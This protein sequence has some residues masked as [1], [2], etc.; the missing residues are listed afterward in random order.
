MKIYIE[1]EKEF[2]DYSGWNF[3]DIYKYLSENNLWYHG[4]E[5]DKR[6]FE[7]GARVYFEGVGWTEVVES[8]RHEDC[9]FWPRRTTLDACVNM[10]ECVGTKRKDAKSVAFKKLEMPESPELQS[11]A[12]GIADKVKKA[13]NTIPEQG[14]KHDAGKIRPSLIPVECIEEIARVLTYGAEK[15][16]PDN[17]K[18]V[19]PERY[20]DALWRHYIAWQKGEKVDAESGLSHAAHFATNAIF[21]LWFEIQKEKKGTTNEKY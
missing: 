12:R 13:G 14:I 21:L 4:K 16:A 1:H 10:P 5:T 15:Y 2:Y 7:I 9:V 3:D 20:H 19:S 18:Q 6:G 8:T 11:T 17:W